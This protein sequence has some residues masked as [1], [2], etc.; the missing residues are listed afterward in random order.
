M[1]LVG[2]SKLKAE[3]PSQVHEQLLFISALPENAIGS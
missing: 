3:L 2:S 1:A